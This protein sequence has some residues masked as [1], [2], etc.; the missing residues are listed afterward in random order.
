MMYGFNKWELKPEDGVDRLDLLP[1]GITRDFGADF[2][3]CRIKVWEVWEVRV[4]RLQ[5]VLRACRNYLA[6][7]TTQ[8]WVCGRCGVRSSSW[9]AEIGRPWQVAGVVQHACAWVGGENIGR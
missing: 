6:A 1:A 8:L 9:G 4:S 5:F 2:W 3:S 7:R